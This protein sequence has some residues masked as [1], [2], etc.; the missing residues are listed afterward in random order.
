MVHESHDSKKSVQT[1][2]RAQELG[3]NIPHDAYCD[4]WKYDLID[5]VVL[6]CATYSIGLVATTKPSPILQTLPNT[7]PIYQ[8]LCIPHTHE[9]LA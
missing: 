7:M 3:Y 9:H 6:L 8:S 5:L 4:A 1:E 2:A